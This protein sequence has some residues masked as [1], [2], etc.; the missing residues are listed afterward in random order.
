MEGEEDE[1]SKDAEEEEEVKQT[2]ELSNEEELVNSALFAKAF[3]S[4]IDH[5]SEIAKSHREE[6]IQSAKKQLEE[7]GTMVTDEMMS[8]A[9]KTF[10]V[11]EA[12]EVVE[13]S[14]SEEEEVDEE[15]LSKEMAEALE[16]VRELAQMHKP[17]FVE[18]ICDLY[19]GLNE[20]E[21][22][23]A[24]LY[25]IFAGIQ[26]KLAEEAIEMDS[27]ID[28]ED[29]EDADI[30]AEEMEMALEQVRKQAQLDQEGL[31]DYICDYYVDFN[32]VEP[33]VDTISDIFSRIK[34][35]LAADAREEFLEENE[36]GD[37]EDDSDY[38]VSD[39]SAA[40]HY[41][42]D[43]E[44]D[45]ETESEIESEIDDDEAFDYLED[46][47]DEEELVN[48]PVFGAMWCSAI[49][50]IESIAK[51]EGV[52]MLWQ[53]VEEYEGETGQ[54]VTEEMV[55]VAMTAASTLDA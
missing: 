30:L 42:S 24:E 6:M 18:K 2:P 49:E 23:T 29:D 1:D 40:E 13:E 37:E 16:A 11:L 38:A 52:D 27:D 48:D 10:A 17:E 39:D 3:A 26:I 4:A 35:Q 55:E 47:E 21:P 25:D 15:E 32:G 14:E 34:E 22:T 33:S 51:E 5:V 45:A 54:Q 41:E 36:D 28:D 46:I 20:E 53:I 7:S 19:E 43:E 8:K 50:H 12:E 31:V 9:M 44:D